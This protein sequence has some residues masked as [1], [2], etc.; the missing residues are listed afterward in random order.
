MVAGIAVVGLLAAAVVFGP[1]LIDRGDGCEVIRPGPAHAAFV[2]GTAMTMDEAPTLPVSYTWDPSATAGV[3]YMAQQQRNDDAWG[4]LDADGDLTTTSDVAP[5]STYGFRVQAVDSCTSPWT[6]VPPFLVKG[7]PQYQADDQG[8]WDF[9]ESSTYWGGN[10]KSTT[11]DGASISL[12]FVGRAVAL[13]G[14]AGPSMGQF[15]ASI[16]GEPAGIVDADAAATTLRSVLAAWDWPHVG[17]H[18]LE[19]V[20][21]PS[22]TG[23]SLVVDGFVVLEPSAG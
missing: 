21:L 4:P 8:T 23:S 6:R 19:L 16:D 17:E 1:A 3:S 20:K 10:A 14:T 18:T 12:S 13:I 9:L 5:Y 2:A 7:Y 11:E 15:E 22:S